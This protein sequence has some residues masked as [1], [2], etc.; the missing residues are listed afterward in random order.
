M[1]TEKTTIRLSAIKQSQ[2]K[3]WAAYGAGIWAFLFAAMCFYWA[4]GGTLGLGTLGDGMKELAH[5][6]ASAFVTALWVTAFLKLLL[7]LL[8]LSLVQ[9]RTRFIPRWILLIFTFVA[10]VG[11]S[12]YG[13]AGLIK[14]A[15]M[16]A[17]ATNI[18]AA[19]GP[20]AVRWYLWFW[21]PLWLAGGILFFTA[22]WH[23]YRASRYRNKR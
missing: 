18:P 9:P 19:I 12:W 2:V 1:N 15:L 17:G 16:E 5:A 22:T 10:G 4:G 23:G 6:R 11:L 21:Q 14:V 8:V 20:Q 3:T 13:G 7:A